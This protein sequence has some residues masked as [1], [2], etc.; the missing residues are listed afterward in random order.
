MDAQ[1]QDRCHR[2]GQTRD[3]HIYKLVSERTV[4]ENIL[5]K[6]NQKRLLGN[7]VIDGGN[8]TTAFFQ[9]QAIRD[10][11]SDDTNVNASEKDEEEE[12]GAAESGTEVKRVNLKAFE[13][14]IAAVE[15]TTDMEV[16]AGN[17]AYSCEETL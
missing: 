1:A 10:L 12:E 3:V 11:F 13:I 16:R 15:D 7:L 9:S 8:F 2:I 6:A 5:R 4:E 17:A 14:A